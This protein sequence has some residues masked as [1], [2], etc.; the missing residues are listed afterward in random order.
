MQNH[1]L[2]TEACC[3]TLIAAGG[4]V[5]AASLPHSDMDFLNTAARIDMFEAHEGEMAQ[6]QAT[7]G[8]VKDLA[9]AL[10][11]DYSTC[12]SQLARLAAKTGTTVPKGIDIAGNSTISQLVNLKGTSFDRQFAK[13]EVSAQRNALAVFQHEAKY[14][15]D[16]SVKAFASQTIPVLE[17]DLKR[18]ETCA[19]LARRT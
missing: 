15:K 10:V 3:F 17:R 19:G 6:N 5:Y 16:A 13:D 1:R 11:Q 8:D 18:A 7:R 4:I 12:Y 14:G 9:N 2:L